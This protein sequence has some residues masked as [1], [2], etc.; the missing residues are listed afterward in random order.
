M[1]LECVENMLNI[2]ENIDVYVFYYVF[3]V[4]CIKVKIN[5]K[6]IFNFKILC[7]V[8]VE[9]VYFYDLRGYCINLIF[10][11]NFKC[12]YDNYKIKISKIFLKLMYFFLF[13]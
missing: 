4:K 11:I 8:L 13:D 3:C 12:I 5:V 7:W 1:N 6:C 2:Y 9:G 10:V